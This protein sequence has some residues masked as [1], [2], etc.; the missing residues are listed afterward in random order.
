MIFHVKG[1]KVWEGVHFLH[2]CVYLTSGVLGTNGVVILHIIS[3][4]WRHIVERESET[5]SSCTQTEE[6]NMTQ[7]LCREDYISNFS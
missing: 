2:P 7:Q 1:S 5:Y 4:K 3:V 6:A